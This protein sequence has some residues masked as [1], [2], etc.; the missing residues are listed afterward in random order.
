[1]VPGILVTSSAYRT[2][3]E[4]ASPV[5]ARAKFCRRKDVLSPNSSQELAFEADT[6]RLAKDPRINPQ[7]TWL[8]VVFIMF[9]LH[10]ERRGCCERCVH[11]ALKKRT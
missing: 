9:G 11:H 7:Q 6:A 5:V 1:M 4:L 8:P 2:H 10:F 3:S